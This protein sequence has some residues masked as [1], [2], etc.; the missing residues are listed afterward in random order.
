MGKVHLFLLNVINVKRQS[1]M[2]LFA[3]LRILPVR[4][5]L[6]VLLITSQI[7]ISQ[8]LISATMKYL[9]NLISHSFF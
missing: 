9:M 5:T 6:S 4:V 3:Q 2:L 8:L 1:I 7:L